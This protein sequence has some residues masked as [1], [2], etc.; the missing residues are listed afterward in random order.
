M[1]IS[2]GTALHVNARLAGVSLTPRFGDILPRL[3]GALGA[4]LL[5]EILPAIVWRHLA[6]EAGDVS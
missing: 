3:P 4:G 2:R 5:E 6:L 1:D